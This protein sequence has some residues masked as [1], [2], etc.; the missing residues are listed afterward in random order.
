MVLRRTIRYQFPSL[1]NTFNC[2]VFAGC[3]QQAGSQSGADMQLGMKVFSC[4]APGGG[5]QQLAST[6]R[7]PTPLP[8]S[9]HCKCPPGT[10]SFLR[11]KVGNCP[12]TPC[13]LGVQ[14]A[15]GYS[16]HQSFRE[17]SGSRWPPSVLPA[18]CKQG[19]RAASPL[20]AWSGNNHTGV[21]LGPHRPISLCSCAGSSTG[22]ASAPA[23]RDHDSLHSSLP[24]NSLQQY[25]D[26]NYDITAYEVVVWM[27]TSREG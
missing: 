1:S 8:S 16:L 25:F 23:C 9:A 3:I 6:P 11:R 15:V 17:A 10:Q 19:H 7:C 4:L 24:V 5:W 27:G 13:V 2:S 20:C 14:V 12:P 22:V 21:T 26:D 18:Q